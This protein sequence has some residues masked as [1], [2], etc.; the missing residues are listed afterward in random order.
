MPSLYYDDVLRKWVLSGGDDKS[1]LEIP[2]SVVGKI[3]GFS[4]FVGTTPA[5]TVGT[6]LTGV[7]TMT[8]VSGVAVGDKIIANPKAALLTG[9]GMV[10]ARIDA[11]DTVIIPFANPKATT[12]MTQAPVGWDVLVLKTE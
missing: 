1:R 2:D 5:V 9:L 11:A 10:G 8:N 6:L 12:V 7:A 3:V 4:V